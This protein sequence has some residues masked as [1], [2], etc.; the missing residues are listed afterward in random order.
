MGYI[1]EYSI[2]CVYSN[3]FDSFAKRRSINGCSKAELFNVQPINN[4]KQ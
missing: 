4:R 2:Y 1:S 3:R